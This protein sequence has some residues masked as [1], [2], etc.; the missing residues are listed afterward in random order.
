MLTAPVGAAADL[1]AR[2]FGG[3]DEIRVF[4]QVIFEQ[5]PEAA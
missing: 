4:A 1:D 5:P 2:P 3:G